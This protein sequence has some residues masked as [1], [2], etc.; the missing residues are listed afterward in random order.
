MCH[1]SYSLWPPSLHTCPHIRHMAESVFRLKQK[2]D[3]AT[4]CFQHFSL[5]SLFWVDSP[6]HWL[7]FKTLLS[8][9]WFSTPCL[10]TGNTGWWI[11][12]CRPSHFL[13][14]FPSTPAQRGPAGFDWIS[15][16]SLPLARV[17][18]LQLSFPLW[19]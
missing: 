12:S 3:H 2:S 1:S 14:V 10:L 6:E 5:S 7:E 9:H 4:L 16:Q 19:Q 8:L 11:P 17:A 18:V 15:G 13:W